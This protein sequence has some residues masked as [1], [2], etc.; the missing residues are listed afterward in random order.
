MTSFSLTNQLTNSQCIK[1]TLAKVTIATL[2][3]VSLFGCAAN[4]ATGDYT[5][6][7]HEPVLT[8]TF[9][10]SSEFPQPLDTSEPVFT[11][12][13]MEASSSV[14]TSSSSS[15]SACGEKPSMTT[16]ACSPALMA[17]EQCL[18]QSGGGV[19]TRMD[20]QYGLAWQC[21]GPGSSHNGCSTQYDAH[22]LCIGK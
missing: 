9:G 19:F 11:S 6:K 8:G 15:E 16:G 20:N 5:E 2:V 21:S 3:N 18:C 7:D 1:I 17:Y 14:S 4:N 13:S 22:C 10:Y 12:I